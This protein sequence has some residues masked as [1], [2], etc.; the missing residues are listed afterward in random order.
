MK[1]STLFGGQFIEAGFQEVIVPAIWEADPFIKKMGDE[2]NEKLWTFPS[3]KG[4]SLNCLIPEVT[5]IIQEQWNSGW[6]RQFKKPFKLFYVSRCYRYD[7]PQ[8]GRY[9]EFTQF[10]VEVLGKTTPEVILETKNLLKSCLEALEIE[11]EFKDDVIRGIGYYTEE[12]FEAESEKL[13][14]QKQ[15]AGG[16]TYNEGVGWAIGVDRVMLSKFS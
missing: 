13:G 3:K 7:R 4:S 14:A 1:S 10:G 12:G 5:A 9:R 11:F 2:K 6:D 8:R 15:I 16:G